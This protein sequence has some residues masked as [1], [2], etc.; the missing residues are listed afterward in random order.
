MPPGP[1][2]AFGFPKSIRLRKQADID[3]VFRQGRYHRMGWLQA[4]TRPNG[5][6]APRFMI[7]VSRRA[8]CAPARNR[9][10]RVVREAIRLNRN[11]LGTP[12][13]I[14]LFVTIQPRQDVRLAEVERELCR[15][16]VRLARPPDALVSD[17]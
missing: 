1:S 16:F 3:P 8:G 2:K 7:S 15:L 17:G 14:C 11:R 5:L 10:K 4:K 6:D 12:H 9:I 13:D